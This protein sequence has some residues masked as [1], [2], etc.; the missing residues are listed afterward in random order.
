MRNAESGN[1][2]AEFGNVN[3]GLG[4]APKGMNAQASLIFEPRLASW[5]ERGTRNQNAERGPRVAVKGLASHGWPR[6]TIGPTI[7]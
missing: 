2:N 3:A 4:N 7:D 5:L 1:V 6:Q